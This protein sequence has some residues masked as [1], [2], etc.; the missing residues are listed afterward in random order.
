MSELTYLFE[1]LPELPPPVPR[2]RLAYAEQ[3]EQKA[4]TVNQNGPSASAPSA[5]KELS[6][7]QRFIHWIYPVRSPAIQPPRQ[8]NPFAV[9]KAG[10]KLVVIA[11]VDAGIISFFGF[12][13][14]AF[15]EF[16]M[17]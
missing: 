4:K 9:L 6:I 5:S 2:R 11:A 15:E 1:G 7:A 10:K 13:Q 8:P 3:K 14:G 17:T 12:R 16:P